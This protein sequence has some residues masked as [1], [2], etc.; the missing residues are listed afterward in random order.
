L[1]TA[2]V[3]A[4]ELREL[5]LQTPSASLGLTMPLSSSIFKVTEDTNAVQI[6]TED[7]TKTV[8]I[9]AGLDPK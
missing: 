7:P 8:Q 1:V 2:A 6:D 4:I 3:V 5:S 9:R